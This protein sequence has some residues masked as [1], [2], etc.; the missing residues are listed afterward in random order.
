MFQVRQQFKNI[1]AE[2]PR[3]QDNNKVNQPTKQPNKQTPQKYRLY[4]TQH[5]PLLFKNLS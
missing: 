5:T 1:T 4:I 2:M 3:E